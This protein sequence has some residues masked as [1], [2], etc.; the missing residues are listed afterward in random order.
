MVEERKD[1]TWSGGCSQANGRSTIYVQCPFCQEETEVYTWSF[2][3]G[4]KKCPCGAI[5][6]QCPFC[7]EETEV[8]TWSFHGGGKKCPC[9][10]IMFPWSAMK[11]KESENTQE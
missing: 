7:Q 9:G 10:A 5:M 11:E 2:H 8:Y 6:F 1:L 3:G 4:G